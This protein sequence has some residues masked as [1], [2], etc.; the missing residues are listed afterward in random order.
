MTPPRGPRLSRCCRQCRGALASFS[1][2]TAAAT[3]RN[4]PVSHQ[5]KPVG[6]H[7]QAFEDRHHGAHQLA[8]V[9]GVAHTPLRRNRTWGQ[10]LAAGHSRSRPASP[11]RAVPDHAGLAERLRQ[12]TGTTV[13]VHARDEPAFDRPLR[14]PA[15][16]NPE[17]GLGRYLLRHPAALRVPIHPARSG[18]FRTPAIIPASQFDDGMTLDVPGRPRVV[19]VPG[20]T[21]GR[22]AFHLP[23]RAAVFTGDALVTHDGLLGRTGTGSDHRPGI[24][25][26]HGTGTNVAGGVDLT[27]RGTCA[28]RSWRP[29]PRRRRRCRGTSPTHPLLI[30]RTVCRRLV[31]NPNPLVTPFI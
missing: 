8:G 16:A 3:P 12:E 26:R 31:R 24:H 1:A 21:P 23:A 14:P 25:A 15:D 13:W 5:S 11:W 28:P 17:A 18:A 19:A 2:V 10:P 9:G 22:V 4:R 20:H 27:G 7:A 30:R 29:G 6:F